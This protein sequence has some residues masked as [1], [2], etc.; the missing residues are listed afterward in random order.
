MKFELQP[1]INNYDDVKKWCENA[2]K[3]DIINALKNNAYKVFIIFEALEHAERIRENGHHIA[4]S[5]CEFVK[6]IGEAK[7][8]V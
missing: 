7:I 5:V 1:Y 8:D 3:E 2:S 6:E 4:Q